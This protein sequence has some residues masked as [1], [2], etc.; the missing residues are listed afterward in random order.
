MLGLLGALT[1]ILVDADAHVV[2]LSASGVLFG[3]TDLETGATVEMI[4]SPREPVASFATGRQVCTAEVVRH[5][6]SGAV[7]AQFE[8]IR[9]MLDAESDVTPFTLDIT[10]DAPGITRD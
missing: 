3:P 9:F 5:A 2:N 6:T 8:D 4:L 7:A 1:E 10:P